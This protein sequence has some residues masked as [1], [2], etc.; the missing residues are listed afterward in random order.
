MSF[1][2]PFFL[3]EKSPE[4]RR[5]RLATERRAWD[6]AREREELAPNRR[7][8][9]VLRGTW[10]E[11]QSPREAGIAQ[12]RKR[13]NPLRD[14]PAHIARSARA[15]G[16]S[17]AGKRG[18]MKRHIDPPARRAGLSAERGACEDGAKRGSERSER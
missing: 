8:G 1:P 5:E 12:S 15:R 6:E 11:G 7:R 18:N 9:L 13:G 14:C 4:R 3:K 10:T 2:P 17:W 16:L